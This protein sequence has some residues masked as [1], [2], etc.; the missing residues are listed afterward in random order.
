MSEG[1]VSRDTISTPLSLE[2]DTS[3]A[4]MTK[5]IRMRRTASS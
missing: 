3:V 5:E 1:L 4:V 2:Q